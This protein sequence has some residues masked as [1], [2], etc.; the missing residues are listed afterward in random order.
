MG[1]E[2]FLVGMI[3]MFMLIVLHV[4]IGFSMLLVGFGGYA[5]MVGITPAAGFV[6]PAASG[7]IGLGVGAVCY[8]AAHLRL[9][10]FILA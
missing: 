8:G 2:Y 4:P 1:T 5:M 7:L 6:T 9:R 3:V 10:A